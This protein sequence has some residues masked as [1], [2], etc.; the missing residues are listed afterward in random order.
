VR[1]F[2]G[3]LRV[4]NRIDARVFDAV[5]QFVSSLR[6]AL[7]TTDSPSL[8]RV[9]WEIAR[10]LDERHTDDS[11]Y[12]AIARSFGME[13]WTADR[14]LLRRLDRRFPGVRFLGDYPLPPPAS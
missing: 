2:D 6:P 3:Y 14:K 5:D 7:I 13:F 11:V 10:D 4:R 1:A 8:L 12:L 9:A